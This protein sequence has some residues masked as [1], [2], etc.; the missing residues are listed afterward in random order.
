[1]KVSLFISV[2]LFVF[3]LKGSTQFTQTVTSADGKMLLKD[4]SNPLLASS[5]TA[6][7]SS[8]NI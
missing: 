2:L 1:M 4:L 3:V 6:T 7:I 5:E 8:N